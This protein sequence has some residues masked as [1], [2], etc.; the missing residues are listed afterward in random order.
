MW[1]GFSKKTIKGLRLATNGGLYFETSFDVPS[2]MCRDSWARPEWFCYISK[3]SGGRAFDVS[4][5][6]RLRL[7]GQGCDICLRS[8]DIETG[9][10]SRYFVAMVLPMSLLR[11]AQ[12]QPMLPGSSFFWVRT[13]PS[14]ASSP[15]CAKILE[16]VIPSWPCYPCR[17]GQYSQAWISLDKQD[18]QIHDL[19]SH[20]H[21]QVPV[22]PFYPCLWPMTLLAK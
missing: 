11:T 8:W 1:R 13:E 4:S 18:L 21:V 2:M 3:S 17:P 10:W 6:A 14:L 5:A 9:T 19:D 15:R 12:N 7:R 16:S 22:P 20:T